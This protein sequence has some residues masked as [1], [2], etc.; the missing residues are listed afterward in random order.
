MATNM[1]KR[2]RDKEKIKNEPLQK[3]ARMVGVST[4]TLSKTKKIIKYG[5]HALT[6]K[7]D[8]HEININKGY[9]I[10]KILEALDDGRTTKDEVN[11][12][13]QE[14]GLIVN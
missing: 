1:N 6:D 8:K 5:C 13:L 7:M 9:Q 3:A 12:A 10:V 4:D 2:I 11:K 14:V